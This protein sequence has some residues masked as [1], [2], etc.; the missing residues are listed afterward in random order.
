MNENMKQYEEIRRRYPE[1]ISKSQFYQIAHISKATALYLLQSGLVPCRDTGKKTRRYTIR[2]DDV[3]FYM[4]DREIHPEVYCAPPNWYRE[5]SGRRTCCVA[6]QNEF[7]RLSEKDKE[8]FRIRIETELQFRNDLLTVAEVVEVI[9]YNSETI[10]RWCK[11]KKIKSFNVSG[12]FLIPKICLI[13]FLISK[14]SFEIKR[15]TWKHLFLIKSFLDQ[16]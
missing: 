13:D 1:T 14:Y 6:Y 8:T 15:K 4:I 5:R 2:T 3:I 10:R 16:L 7:M 9:G 12:K 11:A